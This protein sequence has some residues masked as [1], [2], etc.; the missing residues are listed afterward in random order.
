MKILSSIVCLFLTVSC[1]STTQP[2]SRNECHDLRM[3]LKRFLP[4]RSDEVFFVHVEASKYRAPQKDHPYIARTF[5]LCDQTVMMVCA[6]EFRARIAV[7][8]DSQMKVYHDNGEMEFVEGLCVTFT[9]KTDEQCGFYGRTPGLSVVELSYGDAGDSMTM[10]SL[11]SDS[12]LIEA[13]G[14]IDFR[15]VYRSPF[16]EQ[17]QRDM[18]ERGIPASLAFSLK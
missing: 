13:H 15:A 5:E 14:A 17:A 18:V 7:K 16:D 4:S 2:Q 12:V 3:D 6:N 9:A 1:V 11:S 8:I 10:T